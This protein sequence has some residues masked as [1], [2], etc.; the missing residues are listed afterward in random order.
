MKYDCIIF[1]CDGVLV[2]SERL[3]AQI[4]TDM[5]AE[6]G[7]LLPIA[8]SL[9]FFKRGAKMAQTI[10]DIGEFLAHPL[11]AD[12]EARLRVRS[13]FEFERNLQAVPG[14]E[15]VLDQLDVPFCVASNGPREKM[16]VTLGTTNL[17]PRFGD[18]VFSAYDIGVWKPDPAFYLYAA[19]AM[20]VEP[21]SCAV[22]EDSV[23][24]TKAG[25]A[26]GMVVYGFADLTEAAALEAAGAHVFT[27]MVEL[28]TLLL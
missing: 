17:L 6:L 26:A 10:S 9:D 23:T 18:R 24:G 4:V 28:L 3:T 13:A 20:G 21:S 5:V 19:N 11:P 15:M 22:V 1:D 7:L 25:V 14:I 2:D 8:V 27:S 12:F 16:Q